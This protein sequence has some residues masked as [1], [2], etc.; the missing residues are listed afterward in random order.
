[1]KKSKS[2]IMLIIFVFVVVIF[3][4]CASNGSREGSYEVARTFPLNA[5]PIA[6]STSYY[7]TMAI[8]DDGSLWG[9]GWMVPR[10]LY[11]ST[12]DLRQLR[13]M[14]LHMMDNVYAVSEGNRHTML[15]RTDGTLWAWGQNIV[16]QLGDGTNRYRD[17]AIHVMDNVI[18]V[19]AGWSHTLA[20]TGDG[21]LWAWGH[22]NSGQVGDGT[23]TNRNNPVHIMNDVTYIS[24]GRNHSLAV[25]ANGDLWAWGNNYNGQLGD[26]TTINSNTP[27]LI[28]NNVASASAGNRHS[29]ALTRDGTVWVWGSNTTGQLGNASTINSYKPVSIMENVSIILASD[30]NSFAITQDNALWAWGNNEYGQLGD[31]S[32]ISSYTPIHVMDDVSIVSF[33]GG[34]ASVITLDGKLWAL[35][36][37]LRG[38]VNPDVTTRGSRLTPTAVIDSRGFIPHSSTYIHGY[39]WRLAMPNAD[40][41]DI[42]HERERELPCGGTEVFNARLHYNFLDNGVLQVDVEDIDR[43]QYG[44]NIAEI[45]SWEIGYDGRLTISYDDN[46]N[47]FDFMIE[48]EANSRGVGNVLRLFG[49]D[50][51]QTN[52]A[53]LR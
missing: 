46:H 5:Y 50:G 26:G 53:R 51:Y 52:F 33:S 36:S 32:K 17:Y 40:A 30:Y 39:W 29:M 28:M 20:T 44:L 47:I 23:Y 35:G 16:G 21:S 12:Y 24:A 11:A 22:N 25:S 49:Y 2:T 8:M 9:W 48:R 10:P 31:G 38:H 3:S 18:A 15:L 19:S 14:P 13:Y 45:G 42:V 34:H 37:Y 1:M 4:A 27:V 43:P 7:R 6:V 41:S